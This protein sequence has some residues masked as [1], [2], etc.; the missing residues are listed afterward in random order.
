[1]HCH[2]VFVVFFFFGAA[3]LMDNYHFRDDN[4][5]YDEL[6]WSAF[7]LRHK[8]NVELGTFLDVDVLAVTH[9]F[10]APPIE[11]HLSVLE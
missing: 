7:L 11:E 10:D 4:P 6:N 8:F 1:M 9:I 3:I 2:V 5:A